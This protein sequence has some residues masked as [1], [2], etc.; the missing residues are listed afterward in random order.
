M[1][2]PKPGSEIDELPDDRS[3]GKSRP[4]GDQGGV[5]TQPDDES[6][7]SRQEKGNKG[8]T[9]GFGQGA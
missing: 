7:Q 8:T 1:E 5:S 3:P 6:P 9:P 2:E 4:L